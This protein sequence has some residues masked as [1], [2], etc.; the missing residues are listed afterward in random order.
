[1]LDPAADRAVE[2]LLAP[3]PVRTVCGRHGV[4]SF[5]EYGAGRVLVLLHGIGS[6]SGS[7][8]HQL[9]GLGERYRVLAWDAPG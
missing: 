2:A 8:V 1:M 4:F 6:G 3:F 5:R 7:W 9:A